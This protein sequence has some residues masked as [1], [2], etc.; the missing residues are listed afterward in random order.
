MKD[1]CAECGADLK[2]IRVQADFQN[3]QKVSDDW[4]AV[5][6]TPWLRLWTARCEILRYLLTYFRWQESFRPTPSAPK[7]ASVAMVHSIPELRVSK[8][9]A[10]SL[11]RADQTRLLGSRY[12]QRTYKRWG[13]AD[14]CKLYYI[15]NACMPA[16][17]H[18]SIT[19]HLVY[20]VRLRLDLK[21]F[22]SIRLCYYTIVQSPLC[23]ASIESCNHAIMPPFT[24]YQPCMYAM[25]ARLVACCS[26]DFFFSPRKL[27]LMVDLDQ[28]LIHTTNENIDPKIDDVLHFQLWPGPHAPWWVNIF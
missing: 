10:E 23:Y 4:E 17:V 5:G 9:E 16:H 18:C 6:W 12:F 11:G 13:F 2:K 1:M 22:Q 19:A 7:T 20:D 8:E 3:S 14:L 27:V 28:T 25:H 24:S 21:L 15:G 26:S